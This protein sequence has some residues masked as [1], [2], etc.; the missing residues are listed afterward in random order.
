MA[1]DKDLPKGGEDGTNDEELEFQIEGEEPSTPPSHSSEDVLD[2]NDAEGDEDDDG[3]SS[4]ADSEETDPDR[5]ALRERRRAERQAK[6]RH[7]LEKE[8]SLKR[9]LSAR[10]RIIEEMSERLARVER[11][12]T[13][14]EI[15]QIDTALKQAAGAYDH[16]RGILKSAVE[17]QDGESAVQAQERMELA[18][19]KYEDLTRIKDSY[20]K[21]QQ[22]PQPLDPRLVNHAQAFM[23]NNKWY[24]PTG[25]DEDSSIALAI[26]RR[27]AQEGWNPTTPE[28]WEEL[29]SRVKKYLPHRAKSGNIPSTGARNER[30]SSPVGGSGKDSSGARATTF[31]L[32]KERVSALKEA[33]LWDDPK[34]RNDAIKRFREYDRANVPSKGN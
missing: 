30:R 32:S 8:D 12:S 7:R 18:K 27:M 31:I 33:G 14:S 13:G 17:S 34:D 11:K 19:R 20:Q 26:D 1:E 9:E 16:F 29:G 5:M 3:E 6:K 28:Y 10:D 4:S 21:A 23:E 25:Q 24:D 2:E 15:A 22:A